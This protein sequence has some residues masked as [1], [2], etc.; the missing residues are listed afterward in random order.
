MLL[1]AIA[2]KFAAISV[3][4]DVDAEGAQALVNAFDWLDGERVI[5]VSLE[6][7]TAID[8]R[9]FDALVPAEAEPQVVYVLPVAAAARQALLVA[10]FLRGLHV[11]G[12]LAEAVRLAASLDDAHAQPFRPLPPHWN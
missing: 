7:C 11:A 10:A 8:P 6:A 9:A 12:D 2:G 3:L 1:L 5:I 4:G